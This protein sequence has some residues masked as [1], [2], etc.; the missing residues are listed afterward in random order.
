MLYSLRFGDSPASELYIPTF[1]NT[2]LHDHRWCKNEY[3]YT[4]YEGGTECSES[5]AYKLQM[6]GQS[7]KSKNTKKEYIIGRYKS[8][9]VKLL[10]TRYGVDC[11]GFET[12]LVQVILFSMPVQTWPRAHPVT[13]PGASSRSRALTTH[14]HLTLMLRMSGGI[15]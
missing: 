13:C 4:A 12:R 7:P 6:V 3:T 10:S 14:V 5:S 15:P 8:S 2:L 9:Y 11:P 1:R